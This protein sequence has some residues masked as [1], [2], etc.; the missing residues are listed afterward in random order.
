MLTEAKSGSERLTEEA[1]ATAYVVQ[2]V[3]HAGASMQATAIRVQREPFEGRGSLA[4]VFAD[5]TRFA[6][7]RLWH[8][9]IAFAAPM[10]GPL[11][12]GD[13]R[14]LGLGLLAPLR[15][16]TRD[17]IVF[18]VPQQ[19]D[20]AVDDG[21]A[22]VHAARRALMALARDGDG[23]V[24]RLFSGHEVDGAPATSGRQEHIFIVADD[25]DGD[26]RIDRLIVAAPWACDHSVQ[27]N[28]KMR[29][30][31]EAVVAQLETVRAGRLGVIALGRPEFASSR[32]SAKRTGACLEK[33]H[34]LSGDAP[35]GTAQ[36][37]GGCSRSRPGGRV[38]ASRVARPVVQIVDFAA[39]PN[40]GGLAAHVHLQFAVA[41]RGPLLLG[42]DS[43][44]GGGLF[45]ASA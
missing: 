2:A 42:R 35:R 33:P 14:Y 29:Q 7:E 13:G 5:G 31:F 9:E 25:A 34:S 12:I 24:P 23:G 38:R 45:G 30:A 16:A 27:P 40:G 15:E 37:C 3:R 18:S 17:V 22:L 43:H 36:E 20:I 6:K 28:W 32:R 11:L 41:V 26:C 8:V 1:L 39:L 21:R 44:R 4:E 19:A 10:R